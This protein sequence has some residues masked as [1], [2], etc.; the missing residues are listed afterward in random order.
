MKGEQLCHIANHSELF[1]RGHAFESDISAVSKA[2]REALSVT[3]ETGLGESR[4]EIR[5]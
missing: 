4:T 3:A 5:D 2:M 1:I